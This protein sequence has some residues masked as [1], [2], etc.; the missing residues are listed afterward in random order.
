MTKTP[1]PTLL[2]VDV[3]TSGFSPER[4]V[5]LEVCC[6]LMCARTLD[7]LDTHNSVVRHVADGSIQVPD[8]HE[9]LLRECAG[10]DSHSL[11]AVEGFLLA[12]PWT[13]ANIIVD[14]TKNSFDLRFLAKHMPT[15]YAALTKNRPVLC[16]P[17][18]EMIHLARGGAPYKSAN[19]KTY[20][21]SDDAIETYEA[22]CHYLGMTGAAQ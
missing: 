18:L 15:L 9:A 2:I 8:F 7:V 3:A 20:R 21:A 16:L 1:P 4:D 22:L 19:P 12:G 14:A 6:I 17:A 11:R 13:S 5:I 10:E